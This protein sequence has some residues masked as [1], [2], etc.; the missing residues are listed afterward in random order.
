[1]TVMV[2]TASKHGATWEIAEAI[3]G[4]LRARGVATDLFRLDSDGESPDL[5][6]YE[7]FV[8]GSAVYAGHWMTDARRFVAH[9][10]TLLAVR[11][12]WLFSSGPIGSVPQAAEHEVARVDAM[13]AETGA[14]EHRLFGG[15][16]D[17]HTL[18]FAERALVTAIRAAD[19]DDRDF[20]AIVAWTGQIAQS[21]QTLTV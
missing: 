4:E 12:V 19:S 9:N 7:A 16:I 1:M 2:A 18:G 8:I 14:R 3:A 21:L 17:R 6:G 13:V 20:P 10:R 15:K 11:P 5:A